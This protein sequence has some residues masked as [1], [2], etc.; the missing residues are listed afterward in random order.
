MGSFGFEFSTWLFSSGSFGISECKSSLQNYY[1]VLVLKPSDIRN[2]GWSERLNALEAKV[3]VIAAFEAVH[4]DAPP[5]A[6]IPI[7]DTNKVNTAKYA[8]KKKD[9]HTEAALTVC[10][11][12]LLIGGDCCWLLVLPETEPFRHDI[13]LSVFNALEGACCGARRSRLAVLFRARARR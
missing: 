1:R 11:Y 13:Q 7:W 8:E 5:L 3:H 6:V 9:L 2:V 10:F 12:T 4:A